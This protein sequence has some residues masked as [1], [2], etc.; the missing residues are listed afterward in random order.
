M[1]KKMR[2]KSHKAEVQIPFPRALAMFLVL[3]TVLGLS[4]VWI[5][6][7]CNTL[8]SEIKQ[9]EAEHRTLRQRAISEQD[10]WANLTAPANLERTLKQHNLAMTLPDERQIVRVRRGRVQSVITLAYNQ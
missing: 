4:Y 10:R 6:A 1:K 9:L 5:C 8:G 2:R 7:H 3:V